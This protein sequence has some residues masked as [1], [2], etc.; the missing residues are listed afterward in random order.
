[1]TVFSLP[2]KFMV[3]HFMEIVHR[4]QPDLKM[5]EIYWVITVPAIW[6]DNAKQFMREAAQKV[7]L[8]RFPKILTL[9]T[10]MESKEL[11]LFL[12]TLKW[13]FPKWES[14]LKPGQAV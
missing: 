4:R 11:I 5:N 14:L 3:D 9:M 7:I 12:R 10:M 6:D 8:K 1:M 13:L 2:I